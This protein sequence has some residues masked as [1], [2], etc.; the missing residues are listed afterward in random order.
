MPP[1]RRVWLLLILA[2]PWASPAL[3]AEAD[4]YL[5]ADTELVLTIN[6]KQ[7]LGA[8][9]FQKQV[10][11]RLKEALKQRSEIGKAL[12]ALGFD[13]FADLDRLTLAAPAGGDNDR[14]LLIAHGRFD[15]DKFRAWAEQAARAHGEAFRILAVTDGAGAKHAVWEITLPDQPRPMFAALVAK[16]PLVLSPG[17]EYVLEALGKGGGRKAVLKSEAF[18]ALLAKADG[19]PALNLVGLGGA[20]AKMLPEDSAAKDLLEKVEAVRGGVSVGESLKL[21]LALTA[22]DAAA[23]KEVHK[24]LTEALGQARRSLAAAG[25]PM[26]SAPLAEL[27]KGL[28]TSQEGR[29]VLI[30][31]ELEEEWVLKLLPPRR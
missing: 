21:E 19:K 31:A 24:A 30:K 3:A 13:P 10:V 28:K 12:A 29:A 8:P 6:V 9:L 4:P 7:L 11:P 17:K 26:G 5:P 20:L 16:G 23:A 14:G 27:L 22:Q 1:R 15:P 25:A 18:V 2:L